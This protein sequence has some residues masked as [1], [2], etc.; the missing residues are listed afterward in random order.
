MKITITAKHVKVTAAMKEYA[1]DKMDR[2][3]RYFDRILNIRVLL[4]RDGD[5]NVCEIEVSTAKHNHF[6]ATVKDD[7]D[8]HAAVDLCLDKVER[9]LK[10]IKEKLKGHK[11]AEARKKL[12]RDV[13]RVTTRLPKEDMESYEDVVNE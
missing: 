8:M 2:L 6:V 1:E 9:Q 4:D 12:G 5:N 13:K 11:G 3:E 10:K 7:A